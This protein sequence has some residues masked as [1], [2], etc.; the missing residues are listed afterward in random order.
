MAWDTIAHSAQVQ[1]YIQYN[2]RLP[3]RSPAFQWPSGPVLLAA[4]FG[5]D[6]I[7]FGQNSTPKSTI[8]YDR[9]FLK[10]LVKHVDE[11]IEACSEEQAAFLDTTKEDLTV[12]DALLERYMTLMSLPE[13]ASSVH[14][15]HIPCALHVVHFFPIDDALALHPVL[16]RCESVVLRQEGAAISQGTTG[17]TT[18][19]AS[20]RLAAHLT[21]QFSQIC[22]PQARILELGSGTGF[23]GLVC[24]RLFHT[25]SGPRTD[26]PLVL[27][28]VEGQVLSRLQETV[29][30][31][32]STTEVLTQ[33]TM[34]KTLT[35]SH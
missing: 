29:N 4:Q 3:P 13:T 32:M 5:L 11:A 27:T 21:A 31:S 17:L 35:L 2:A 30:L 8:E 7:L 26:F 19:E 34:H 25:R 1:L 16:G 24:S 18:W 6:A 28:D 9:A 10:H 23:L 12:D 33:Q 15:T 20:L 22:H 14:G